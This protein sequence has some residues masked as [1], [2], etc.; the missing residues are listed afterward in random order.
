[1]SREAQELETEDQAFATPQEE[2]TALEEEKIE[3]TQ[4]V[5]EIERQL[6]SARSSVYH[7]GQYADPVWFR[8]ASDAKVHNT[9]RLKW[10]NQRIQQLQR[11]LGADKR[12]KL[13]AR[14][15]T[16]E[17]RFILAA[18]QLLP[19]SQYYAIWQVVNS[20]D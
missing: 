3:L 17:R 10:I 5:S 2:L 11:Q 4:C 6:S 15:A 16:R 13:A 18:K 7:G 14:D 12:A 1:M 20:F 9:S 8:R 19:E